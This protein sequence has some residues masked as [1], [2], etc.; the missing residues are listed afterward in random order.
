MT[1]A[2][3]R[4]T[5][6]QTQPRVRQVAWA[7][8]MACTLVVFLALAARVVTFERFLPV[9][10]HY[11]ESLRFLHA[12]Q[13]RED[14]PLG[15]QYG[16]ITW[17]EGFPPVQPWVGTWM[18]RVVESVVLFPYPS[19]YVYAMRLVSVTGGILTTLLLFVTG[20]LLG[21]PHG[22]NS[23]LVFGFFAALP[24]ALAPQIVATGNFA[25]IDPLIYPVFAAALLSAVYSIQRDSASAAV[26]SLF[27]VIVT[28]YT[29]YILIYALWLPACAVAVLVWRRGWR[30]MLPWIAGM[31]VL[32][33]VT[34]GWLV[35]GFRALS[36][37]NTEAT[38]FYDSGLSNI[39]SLSRNLDNLSFTIA[40]TIG[41]GLLVGT[42]LAGT[43]AYVWNRRH[44]KPVI[45]WRWLVL[46]LPALAGC[47]LLTSSVEVI[48]QAAP[49]WYRIRYTLPVAM[50]FIVIWAGAVTQIALALDNVRWV[51]LASLAG[52]ALLFG[53]PATLGNM[54][55]ASLYQQ[56]HY[57]VQLWNWSDASL[58]NPDGK[59][60]MS[61]TGFIYDAWNRPWSGYDGVTTFEWA[62]DE[63]PT[64]ST[65]RE[66]HEQ[67]VTYFAATE[68]DLETTFAAPEIQEWIDQLTLLKVIRPTSARPETQPHTVY[69]YR[70]LPP[71]V[72]PDNATFGDQISLV[73]Y[74]LN[75]DVAAPGDVVVLRPYWRAV[76]QPTTNYSMF[77]H[78]LPEGDTQPVTQFDGSPAPERRLPVTWEDPDELLVG[79]DAALAL[80]AD[81]PIGQYR[82]ALGLYDFT[83]GERLTL[84][85]GSDT[86]EVE[87][88]VE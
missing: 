9:L 19:D 58:P 7:G 60:L 84:P 80:P 12:Y 77:V 83:T 50:G 51:R 78:L 5:T 18:Q 32:S 56:E 49:K 15:L 68:T 71:Q 20:W 14:A 59:I 70:M 24:W 36:L 13:L 44:D 42:L 28:I 26:M 66:F 16:V 63:N 75:T 6:Q 81:L 76:R 52:L 8:V 47:I 38:R 21:Q 3:Y 39:L 45:E 85:D 31:A 27:F 65:P 82:L 17:A 62:F 41:V 11:D 4:E 37:S 88:V 64:H 67:G 10:D 33:A 35:F 86:Y 72:T 61:G 34:A 1:S 43:A 57:L 48:S 74:D 53:I 54:A 23:A 25:L 40:E 79:T 30:P 55:N 46:L 29:K 2:L 69:F 73:G 87:L 22:R